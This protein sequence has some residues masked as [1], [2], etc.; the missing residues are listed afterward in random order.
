MEGRLMRWTR[1]FVCLG[2]AALSAPA[3]AQD[4]PP[5]HPPSPGDATPATGPA[6]TEPTQTSGWPEQ[7]SDRP[8]TLNAGM[9]EVHG[10][11]P[12]SGVTGNTD[13]I[14]GVGASYGISDMIE[15]GGDYA[16][17]LAP[18]ADAAGILTGHVRL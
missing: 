17:Q 13:V 18:S 9:L 1:L 8:Y 4:A 10:A 2:I 15:V 16:F 14:L 12:F 5:S 6:S 7:I 11:L 3:L